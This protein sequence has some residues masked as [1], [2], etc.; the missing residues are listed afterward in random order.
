MREAEVPFDTNDFFNI[1]NPENHLQIVNENV[2]EERNENLNQNDNSP[3][4]WEDSDLG[5][6]FQRNVKWKIE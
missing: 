4:C 6:D 1:A 2:E 5:Q 3:Q